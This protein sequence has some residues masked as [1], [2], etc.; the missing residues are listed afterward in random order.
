MDNVEKDNIISNLYLNMLNVKDIDNDD[1]W[2]L[3][4]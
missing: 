3:L 1:F 2:D 4:D